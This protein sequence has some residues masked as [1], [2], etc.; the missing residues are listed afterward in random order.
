MSIAL[1]PLKNDAA[2]GLSIDGKIE[3]SDIDRISE[4]VEKRLQTHE[5]LRVYVE[6][7][8]LGGISLEAL[9]EDLKFAFKHFKDFDRKAVVC[10]AKWVEPAASISNRLF[11]HIEVKCF[12]FDRQEEARSW[13]CE[14]LQTPSDRS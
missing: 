4:E 11:R 6:M 9:F 8:R 1:I 10:D 2:I 5:Q 13:I 7:K 14:S 12:P 3:A